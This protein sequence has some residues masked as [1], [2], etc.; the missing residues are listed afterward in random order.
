MS[1]F[2]GPFRDASKAAR[3][4]QGLQINNAYLSSELIERI[5]NDAQ[6]ELLRDMNGGDINTTL[7]QAAEAGRAKDVNRLLLFL[8]ADATWW[9]SLALRKASEKG[10]MDVVKA[11]LSATP[12]ADVNAAHG[13][14][15][16][17]AVVNGHSEVALF[18]LG[19]GSTFGP[20]VFTTAAGVGNV[21]LV[22]AL[23]ARGADVHHYEDMALSSAAER[24]HAEVVKYLLS[25]GADC[26][27]HVDGYGRGMYAL[28][29]TAWAGQ[30]ET[31]KLLLAAGS[32]VHSGGDYALW[33]A[34][35]RGH[36]EVV[37]VLLAAG[38]DVNAYMDGEDTIVDGDE[39]MEPR[40]PDFFKGNALDLAVWT[41]NDD[42]VQA[43]LG[44]G[45]TMPV[46]ANALHFAETIGEGQDFF[47]P[48]NRRTILMLRNAVPKAMRIVGQEEPAAL[49]RL[50]TLEFHE[51]MDE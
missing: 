32:D 15:L 37:K 18:L 50:R 4:G 2:V 35:K 13:A 48:T 51:E 39:D 40:K 10:R 21:T 23:V 28:H 12:P 3:N 30:L 43:L 20:D 44:A 19:A 49:V 33:L 46:V 11:L 5:D 7:V 26:N 14:A 34:V 8:H 36:L 17:K 22:R 29:L 41:Q 25:V 24:G 45:P 9:D 47:P 38:A 31:T 6:V 16:E 27:A 42:V 1:A